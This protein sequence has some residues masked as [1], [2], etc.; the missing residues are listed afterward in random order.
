MKRL[1]FGIVMAT[2]LLGVVQANGHVVEVTTTLDVAAAQ[3]PEKLEQALRTAVDKILS[4]TVA[5]QPT[6]VAVTNAH[7]VGERMYVR[8]LLADADGEQM[9]KDVTRGPGAAAQ[10]ETSENEKIRL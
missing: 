7:R 3:D 2:W 9:L 1:L 6:L 8:I 10:E 5:F 4:D